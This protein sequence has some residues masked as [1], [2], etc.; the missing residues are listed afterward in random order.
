MTT[1]EVV[2]ITNTPL[3]DA[4]ASLP[5]PEG[6]DFAN[7]HIQK[8]KEHARILERENAKLRMVMQQI[9]V[10]AESQDVL[11]EWWP[12]MADALGSNA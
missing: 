5:T 10:D 7:F 3:T 8:Y 6:G 9:L 4:L 11:S 1:R 2:C 12:I